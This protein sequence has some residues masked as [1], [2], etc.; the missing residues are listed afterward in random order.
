MIELKERQETILKIV[1]E[2]YVRTGKPVGSKFIEE[3]SKLEC[4]S[5]TIRQEMS[6]LEQLEMLE[7]LHT[8]GGRKPTSKGYK[9]YVSKLMDKGKTN[10]NP[11]KEIF[12]KRDKS[13]N[14]VLENATRILSETTN[15]T[16]VLVKD[17]HEEK[18]KDINFTILSPTSGLALIIT[19]KGNVSNKTFIVKDE[20]ELKDIEIAIKL[21]SQRLNGLPM[22]DVIE[23]INLLKPILEKQ[24]KECELVIKAMTNEFL[25]MV[26]QKAKITGTA[27]LVA[28]DQ[29]TQEQVKT[30]IEA[31]ENNSAF[32]YFAKSQDNEKQFLIGKETGLG[33]DDV[34][35]VQHTIHAGG[36][37]AKIA[38]IGH[39][40][41]DYQ[42][43]S[44]YLDQMISEIEKMF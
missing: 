28:A 26:A 7:Q 8:S 44:D 9:Y 2:E 11:I 4:S 43:V 36:Q 19:D 6:T 34:S 33:V 22:A 30:V 12:D 42:K 5:A 14:D 20:K 40:R 10:T 32:D 17:G 38:L 27:N 29:L 25:R 3:S 15:L 41:M 35:I 39:S 1:V 37:N 16:A 24:V 23:Q 21:L 13:I 31:L 18:V